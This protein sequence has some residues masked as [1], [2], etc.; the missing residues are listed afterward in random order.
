VVLP[1]TNNTVFSSNG[2]MKA[3]VGRS[4]LPGQEAPG[5]RCKARESLIKAPGPTTRSLC[6]TSPTPDGRRRDACPRRSLPFAYPRSACGMAQSWNTKGAWRRRLERASVMAR[7]AD[8][9]AFSQRA[10]TQLAMTTTL[11]S[12]GSARPTSP[13]RLCF[14][15]TRPMLL[16]GRTHTTTLDGMPHRAVRV[17]ILGINYAPEPTGIAPYATGLAAGL[18][19]RGHEVQVLTG[20]SHY[21]QWKRDATSSGFRS[22]EEIDGVRVRRLN[23]YVPQHL[24]WLGR[25]AMELTFGLQLLTSGWGRPDVVVCVTPPLLA[26][27]ICAVRGRLTWRRPAI[28]ILVHDVYSR[29][30]AE[31]RALSGVTARMMRALESTALRLAD[32]VAVIHAGFTTDLVGDLGVDRRRIREIRNWNHVKSPDPSASVAF[33]DAHRWGADEVVVLHAGN[34]GYKQGLENVIAAAELA[35]R[36]KSRARFVLLGD[37]NQRVA[38][39]AAGAGLHTLEFLSVVNEEEF[40]AALGAA[41]VLLVNERPGVAQ[42]AV[43]SKLTSYFR[44]GKPILA[45]TDSAGFTAGELAA[46]GAGVCVPA[47]RPD[48]LLREALR[49][50]TDHVLGAALG[51]AGRRYCDELLSEKAAMDRYERWI[52]DLAAVR[53]GVSWQGG[54]NG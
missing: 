37:G 43:P 27:A 11:R 22:V 19:K 40:P 16:P 49:L 41:D 24:S 54:H 45:A 21:P 34:M 28:G 44:S 36:N 29:G 9:S 10:V 35:D 30:V 26:T 53:R 47:D 15:P 39:E 46:S 3:G 42:M 14:D 32:D 6:P 51:E 12:L 2:L 25:A 31:T 20:Y 7:R 5:S 17:A 52:V 18:M 4:P 8:S 13:T 33:R 1:A 23:H 38:L 48:M 50:G